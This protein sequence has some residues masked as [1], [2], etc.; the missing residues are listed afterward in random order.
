MDRTSTGVFRPSSRNQIKTIPTTVTVHI[1]SVFLSKADAYREQYKL[2]L[3]QEKFGPV[4]LT[5]Q[6]PLHVS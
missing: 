2:S 5:P 3:Q 4:H 6:R 1:T